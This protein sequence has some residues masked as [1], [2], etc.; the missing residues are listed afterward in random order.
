MSAAN[1]S[2]ATF[3]VAQAAH[4]PL[5][6]SALGTPPTGLARP[7]VSYRQSPRIEGACHVWFDTWVTL[8]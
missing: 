8:G 5:Q 4:Y 2:V 1:A 3:N 6:S 7:P